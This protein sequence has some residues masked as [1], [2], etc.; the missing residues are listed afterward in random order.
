MG[1]SEQLLLRFSPA[2]DKV[3]ENFLSTSNQVV[4]DYLHKLCRGNDAETEQLYLWGSTASG[5]SHLLQATCSEAAKHGNRCIFV[6]LKRL[7]EGTSEIFS[8]LESIDIICIDDI[9]Y[10]VE[11]KLQLEGELFNLINRAR[12]QSCRLIMAGSNNPRQLQLTLPDLRSR[13]IWGNVCQLLVLDDTDKPAAL[14]LHAKLRGCEIPEAVISYLLN[15][16]PRDMHNLIAVTN[17]IYQA[18]FQ[19]KQRITLPFVKQVLSDT[20]IAR[21]F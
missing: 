19:S 13:L 5:K 20:T 18:S 11:Q 3:F 8:G 7:T 10:M 12:E 2:K 4:V 1:T 15:H 21:A 14:S 16:Y 17:C 9:D 6:P